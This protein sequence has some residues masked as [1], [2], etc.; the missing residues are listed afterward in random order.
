MAL[1]MLGVADALAARYASA[2][3]TPPTGY[4]NIR[5]STARTPNNIPALPFVIVELPQGPL[6]Y[7]SGRRLGTH[8]FEVFFL[9]SRASGDVPRD[10]VAMLS[11]LSVLLDQLHAQVKLGLTSVMKAL[12]TTY[13]S[14]NATYAG[15][16]YYAWQ[17]T[18][19]VWTED[20]V[21]LT[22]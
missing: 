9:Y 15:Q 13:A 4:T 10:K 8:T 22:P 11:W 20:S 18:V 21:T 12:V 3:V 19:Q 16:D 7:Q 5:G 6:T 2:V 14:V 17:I 1:D